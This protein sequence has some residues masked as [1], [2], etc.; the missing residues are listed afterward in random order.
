MDC[1]ID[2]GYRSGNGGGSGIRGLLRSLC[3][4]VV[5]GLLLICHLLVRIT[6]C[7]LRGVRP[8]LVSR[9]VFR[10]QS[11]GLV[12]FFLSCSAV[13]TRVRRVVGYHVFRFCLAIFICVFFQYVCFW[14]GR[15][16]CVYRKSPFIVRVFVFRHVLRAMFF[17]ALCYVLLLYLVPSTSVVRLKDHWQRFSGRSLGRQVLR[18]GRFFIFLVVVYGFLFQGVVCRLLVGRFLLVDVRGRDF[19]MILRRLFR[20]RVVEGIIHDFFVRRSFLH[21]AAGVIFNRGGTVVF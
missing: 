11:N 4:V 16:R 7:L 15:I 14:Q 18:L 13:V 17:R 3:L 9:R 12:Q 1:R 2:G 21:P 20:V 10:F 19:P 5:C 6:F 8:F